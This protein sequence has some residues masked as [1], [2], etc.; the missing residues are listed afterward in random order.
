MTIRAMMNANG[1]VHMPVFAEAATF[2]G[3]VSPSREARGEIVTFTPERSVGRTPETF[4]VTSTELPG[5]SSARGW[6]RI[7]FDGKPN[8]LATRIFWSTPIRTLPLLV[9]R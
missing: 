5:S 4:S 7:V 9:T 8:G 2:G 1:I 3:K 6:G